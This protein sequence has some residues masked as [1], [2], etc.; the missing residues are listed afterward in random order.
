VNEQL[1]VGGVP[2]SKKVVHSD[3]LRVTEAIAKDG[4]GIAEVLL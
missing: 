1:D 3:H 4:K 2:K